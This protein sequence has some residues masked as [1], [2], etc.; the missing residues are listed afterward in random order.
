M[1][2]AD[3]TPL[4]KVKPI[5]VVSKQI[6]PTSLTSSLSKVA[7][8]FVVH[9]FLAPAILEIVDPNQFGAIPKSS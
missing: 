9:A 1:K 3:V 8:D 4:P 6:R 5:T 2:Y 7:E